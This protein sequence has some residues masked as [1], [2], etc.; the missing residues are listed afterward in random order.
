MRLPFSAALAGDM[1]QHKIDEIFKEQPTIFGIADDILFVD[2]SA[3]D[4]DHK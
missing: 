1:L 3:D 2:Y 4:K